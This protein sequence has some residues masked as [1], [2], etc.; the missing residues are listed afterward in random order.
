[1][2]NF[3]AYMFYISI[4]LLLT[5]GFHFIVTLFIYGIRFIAADGP[6]GDISVTSKYFLSLGGPIFYFIVMTTFFFL[7]RGILKQFSIKIKKVIP[8]I[9]NIFVTLYLI[10]SFYKNVFDLS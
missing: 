9:V 8:L 4:T 5:Y 10:I 7:Y 1:M 6:P 3:F 2:K